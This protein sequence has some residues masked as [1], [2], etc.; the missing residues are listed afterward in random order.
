MLK[1]GIVTLQALYYH[2]GPPM[3]TTTSNPVRTDIFFISKQIILR[4]Q[5]AN[6]SSQ[7]TKENYK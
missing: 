2:I 7:T 6:T 5:E 1:G 4:E 3:V